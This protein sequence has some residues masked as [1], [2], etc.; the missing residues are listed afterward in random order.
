VEDHYNDDLVYSPD[1]F[2]ISLGIHGGQR[3]D[4]LE[5]ATKPK[6][7]LPPPEGPINGIVGLSNLGNTCFF[8]SGTQCLV[9]S[10]LLSRIVL[11]RQWKI[12]PDN[13]L[14]MRGRIA[15]EFEKTCRAI[16][17]GSGSYS[18]NGL[19]HVIGQ[20]APKFAGWAQ[21]DSHELVTF[22]LDG[23][24]EDINRV[25]PR[26][27]YDEGV[28][29]DGS[30]DADTAARAWA[31]HTK[32]NNSQVVQLFH[33]QC[34]SQLTCPDCKKVTVV[35]DPYVSL[36]VPIPVH[37]AGS[38]SL[39]ECFEMFT[40]A[41]ILDENNQWFCPNCRKF[42]CA[43]KKADI[44]SVPPVLIIQLKRF[45]GSGYWI[46]KYDTL[47][48]FPDE[49]DMADFMC[50][51]LP[52]EETKY[53]LYAVSNHSGGLGGGHYTANAIVQDPFRAPDR[54]PQWC[55]FN[56]SWASASGSSA[57]HGACAYVLFYERLTDPEWT[58]TG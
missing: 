43:E 51:K 29:G 57:P 27:P 19:K 52:P 34:R 5:G 15:A 39:R 12:N 28:S 36:Q 14:G 4:V 49:L 10:R 6:R 53:R 1:S 16:W 58:L 25:P 18:P 2:L 44:W 32:R 42:V 24:H 56:D 8:N 17:Y 50:R 54:P 7:S 48:D 3:L 30:N 11:S 55:S 41:E 26:Q 31:R 13:P 21:Q 45:K 40:E 20:F 22:M 35:F 23:L 33:G 46:K 9:H 47:I 38:H 37:N